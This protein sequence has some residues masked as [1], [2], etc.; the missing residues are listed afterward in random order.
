M[1]A[2]VIDRA[3][4]RGRLADIPAPVPGPADAVVRVTYA[5]VN[6][7]DW[8][9]RDGHA[10][11]IDQSP[12]VLGQ[13]F[14]GIVE[15]AGSDVRSVVAGDRVFGVARGSGS[16]AQRT[17]VREN[18]AAS[19]FARI[20]DGVDDATAAALPTPLLT[21]FG[22]LEMLHVA[23]GTRL[24]IAGAAGS[25]GS[26]AL[27][28]ARA[29]GADITAIVKADQLDRVRALGASNAVDESGGI[30]VLGDAKYDAVLDL[31]SDGE[32]LKRYN[33]VLRPGGFLVTTI[34]DADVEWFAAR[35]R[36]ASNITMAQTPQSSPKGLETVARFVADGTI[37]VQFSERPLDEAPQILDDL[38]AGRTGGKIVL[39]VTSAE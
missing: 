13:D 8:K 7:I 1:K 15:S 3:G 11:Q 36:V 20:P 12:F 9:V 16:Y 27:Q 14:A 38:S 39:R 25:V 35:D 17:S 30:A 34:H 21:A 26:A 22:A 33:T 24:I 28:M 23:G 18:V 37:R 19:P 10:G 32:T 29:R 6:P 5:G 31:V 2:I 4:E